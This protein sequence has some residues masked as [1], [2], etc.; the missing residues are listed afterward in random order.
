MEQT[1]W[2]EIACQENPCQERQ[3][4]H[5]EEW[6]QKKQHQRQK[7]GQEASIASKQWNWTV[8]QEE[9]ED[10]SICA[11]RWS[12]LDVFWT[13]S[14]NL[15]FR[16]F[17]NQEVLGRSDE[18]SPDALDGAI[19]ILT[20]QRMDKMWHRMTTTTPTNSIRFH[21]STACEPDYNLITEEAID[22]L[23]ESCQFNDCGK[24]SNGWMPIDE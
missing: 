4:S 9:L 19:C 6:W 23:I 13:A 17:R 16:D 7:D 12:C 1:Y 20:K 11:S 10:N 2:Q 3:E 24:P 21:E 22:E 18:R 5:K 14:T 15:D 8:L